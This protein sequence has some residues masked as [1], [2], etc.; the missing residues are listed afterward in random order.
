[1]TDLEQP[2]DIFGSEHVRVVCRVNG[3]PVEFTVPAHRSLL[4]ELRDDLG[5]TG[6]KTCCAE[7]ECGACTVLVDGLTVNSCLMLA[8]EAGGRDILTIEGLGSDRS[9]GLTDLQ[10][11][12]LE[13]GA[14]QCGFCIPGQVMAAEYLLRNQ[15]HPSVEQIR[16]HM[17]GNLCRC[18]GY[19]RIVAAIQATTDKRSRHD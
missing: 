11:A 4:D 1:M 15:A 17:S 7:G 10:E 19:Q 14:V 2:S 6:T 18:A 8:A 5:L 13:N 9:E 12:F 16:E 3:D